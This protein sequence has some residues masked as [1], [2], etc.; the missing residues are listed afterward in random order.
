MGKFIDGLAWLKTIATMWQSF[1]QSL[2]QVFDRKAEKEELHKEVIAEKDEN[3]IIKQNRKQ[4]KEEFRKDK[5]EDRIEKK[6][7][8]RERKKGM[9]ISWQGIELIKRHEGLRLR[10]YDDLQPYRP[11]INADQIKGTLT[12]GYGHTLNVE[13]GQVITEEQAEGLL[14]QDLAWAEQ[15]VNDLNLKLNQNQFDSLVSWVF[16]TGTKNLKRRS[17]IRA[18]KSNDLNQV[19]EIW[20]KHYVTSKG[21]KLAGLVKR[22]K[23]EAELFI[24]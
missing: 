11:I 10:A 23:E 9:K 22:R 12:I 8:K 18:I 2:Q 3:R 17:L 15:A 16:N 21:K 13:V 14:I 4:I 7:E 19:R 5:T 20:N 6:R 24:S 1:N